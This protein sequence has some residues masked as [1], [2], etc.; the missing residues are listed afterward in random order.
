MIFGIILVSAIALVAGL[1]AAVF[2]TE[3]ASR[4]GVVQEL[5]REKILDCLP[6]ENCGVCGYESCADLALAIAKGEAPY[7]ACPVGGATASQS[8]AVVMGG[9]DH[10]GV[11]MRAQVMCSGTD[12]N[13]RKK[14]IYESG[15]KDCLAASKLGGG[16]KMC[17]YACV[18]LGSC[19]AACPFDAISVK[20]GVANVEYT[21]CNGCGMCVSACPKGIIKLI[22]Y[23]TYYWVGCMSREIGRRSA[24]GCLSGCTG[25][26][27]CL[28]VCPEN[29]IV[30][31][32][33]RLA[34]IDYTKCSGCGMC[35]SVCPRGVIWKSDA[36][37]ADGLIFT[38]G[39][40]RQK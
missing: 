20:D 10:V 17:K 15:A 35:F 30:L 23:D 4:E 14:Y 1:A 37:G 34:E 38:K 3:S 21:K 25:C 33:S 2:R 19:A 29:A 40:N 5:N 24:E 32:K 39:E 11:R 13:I 12:G 7:A 28:R 22:P 26:G 36:F 16:D 6:G 27:E 31:Q 18:G 9:E 8:I